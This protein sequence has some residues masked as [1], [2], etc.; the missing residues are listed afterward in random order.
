MRRHHIGHSWQPCQTG[1]ARLH[2]LRRPHRNG[3]PVGAALGQALRRLPKRAGKNCK[4]RMVMSFE[5]MLKWAGLISLVL[6]IVNMAWI[7]VN[8]GTDE[9]SKKQQRHEDKLIDHDRRVQA[10]EGELKHVPS[11]DQFQTM[12]LVVAKLEGHM[13]KVESE[14]S[15]INHTVRR[16]DDYLRDE[17]A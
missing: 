10:I 12:Q 8:R 15:T 5:Q 9:F 11:K 7:L 1:F 3:T 6:T 13:G 4:K 2:R 16:I 14:V 17:K